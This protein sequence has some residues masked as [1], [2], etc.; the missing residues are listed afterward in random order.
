MSQVHWYARP[1]PNLVLAASVGVLVL[2]FWIVGAH[3]PEPLIAGAS[4]GLISGI[5]TFLGRSKNLPHVRMANSLGAVILAEMHS[6]WTRGREMITVACL[7]V[8]GVV[9]AR[10]V[11]QPGLYSAMMLIASCEAMSSLL[12]AMTLGSWGEPSQLPSN[13]SLERTRDR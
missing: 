9:V 5:L 2:P 7:I 12:R 3:S 1:L 10:R 8:V 11:E 6:P 13:T 4:V